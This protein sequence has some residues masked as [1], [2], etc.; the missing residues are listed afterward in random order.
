M[1]VVGR[2][3]ILTS[4][5]IKAM[6]ELILGQQFLWIVM[7]QLMVFG[8]KDVTQPCGMKSYNIVILSKRTLELCHE[9]VFWMT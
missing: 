7:S 6:L 1:R 9:C 4:C 3:E 8:R 5:P 2:G